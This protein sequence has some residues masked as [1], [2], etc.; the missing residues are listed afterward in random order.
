MASVNAT[1]TVTN[2]AQSIN[3]TGMRVR[4]Q[5]S[6]D[7]GVT[8]ADA[9]SNV[10]ALG[11]TSDSF[12]VPANTSGQFRAGAVLTDGTNVGTEVFSSAVSVILLSTPTAISVGL[13]LP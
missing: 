3:Y 8:W 12:I 10:R 6:T 1:I 2:Q 7:G 4:F 5:K 9:Q 11:T 13:V